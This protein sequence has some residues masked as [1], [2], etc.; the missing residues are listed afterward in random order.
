MTAIW[1]QPRSMLREM[2]IQQALEWAFATECA[3]LDFDDLAFYELQAGDFDQPGRDT[4]TTI[5]RRGELGCTVDGGG[6]SA[7]H[8]DALLIAGEVA[9]LP[10]EVGGKKMAM[11]IAALARARETPDWRDDERRGVV[12]CGWDM[13]DRG[14][15]LAATRKLAPVTYRHARKRE[16]RTYTPELCPISYG[17]SAA[18]IARRRREYL[19]WVGALLHLLSEMTWWRLDTI[20]VVERL[21]PYAP[22]NSS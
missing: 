12:P 8:P 19:A 14:E 4:I 3:Q 13:T 16:K 6:T 17:G 18:V 20:R 11:R 9:R 5:Q 10:F 7:P 22:W 2:T 15:W 1:T 21:P